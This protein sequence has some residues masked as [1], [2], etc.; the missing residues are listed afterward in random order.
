MVRDFRPVP[1]ICVCLFPCSAVFQ[2]N[3]GPSCQTIES[4]IN[5]AYN[6][7][8]LAALSARRRF[9]FGLGLRDFAIALHPGV[10]LLEFVWRELVQ[11]GGLEFLRRHHLLNGARDLLLRRT[12]RIG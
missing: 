3:Y 11:T 2:T 10:E 9:L 5:A 6:Q 12:G 1:V 4:S 8:H 7:I